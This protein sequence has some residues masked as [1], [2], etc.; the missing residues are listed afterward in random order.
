M[1]IDW[2]ALDGL[3]GVALIVVIVWAALKLVKRL[4]VGLLIVALIAVVFFGAHF[5]DFGLGG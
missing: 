4:I 5:R 3:L 2:S 1:D